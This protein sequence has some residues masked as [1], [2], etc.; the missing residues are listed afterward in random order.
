MKKLELKKII[1]EEV[2]KNN[3]FTKN[4]WLVTLKKDLKQN[5]YNLEKVGLY[6]G[7]LKRGIEYLLN[8]LKDYDL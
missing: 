4:M 2:G 3:L 1:K 8:A 5:K 7:T 6:S